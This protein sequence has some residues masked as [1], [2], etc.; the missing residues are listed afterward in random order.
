MLSVIWVQ[1]K[2]PSPYQIILLYHIYLELKGLLSVKKRKICQ[3]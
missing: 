1:E 2:G 3:K